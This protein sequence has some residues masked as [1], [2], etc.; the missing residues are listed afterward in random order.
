MKLKEYLE[1]TEQSVRA[2]AKKCDLTNS[3]I[4]FAVE[5]KR[6]I[7]LKTA[8]LIEKMTNG[9]VPL[10]E[11]C[12]EEFKNKLKKTTSPFKKLKKGTQVKR[13]DDCH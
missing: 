3:I 12:D 4:H 11:L 1:A 7:N 6:A 2:F 9:D 10:L 5:G 13:K 8:L